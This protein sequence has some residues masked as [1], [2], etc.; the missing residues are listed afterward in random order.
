MA[1]Y[2][3]F[4]AYPDDAPIDLRF[5]FKD[6]RPAGKHGFLRANGD[7]FEFEDGTV[8]RF[9]GTNLNGGANFPD[10]DYAEKSARRLA[11]FGI[12][13]VRFH[14]IDAEWD[15]P[16]IYSFTKGPRIDTTRVL[17]PVSL[18]RLDYYIYC[19]KQE[20]IYCYMDSFTY[21]K[22]KNSDGIEN[23]IGLK[24][25]AKPYCMYNRRMI[26]LQKEMF[27]MLW[28]H[29]NP[30]TGLAY[31]DDPVFVMAELVNECDLF[32]WYPIET[33]PYA[34]E[35][36]KNF[37]AWLDSKGIEYDA[38]GCD[39]NE[40]ITGPLL[41]YK[42]EVQNSYF[43]EM[44]GYIRELGIK[45]PVTGTNWQL[46]GACTLTSKETDY[47]DNHHY[48]YDWHWG[49]FDKACM[50][51]GI[52]QLYDNGS[53]IFPKSHVDDMP[54]FIS[55]WD[56]PWPNSFRAEAPIFFASVGA[57][58]GYSGFAIH[59]YAYGTR[60][61]NMKMLGKEGSSQTIGGVSYREG[62]FS[63]WNDPA[64]FGLFYHAAL[65]T[66]RGDVAPASKKI[67]VKIND[68]ISS[69]GPAFTASSELSRI[70][71]D[72][73][74]GSAISDTDRTVSE[75]EI[76]VPEEA[77]EVRSDNGQLYR[78]WKKNL[79]TVDTELT[80]CVYGFLAKNGETELND[81]SVKC[82]NDFAV[83]AM[84]SLD[85]EKISSS[86]N[87]LLTT[88]GRAFN[89]DAR[90]LDEKMIDYG[91]PPIMIEVINADIKI[92]TECP[93]LRVWA[94]NSEGFYVGAI[95]S[96]YKDGVLS[97]TVGTNFRSMYYLIQSE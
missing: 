29:V 7:H 13:L 49:E 35:F 34:T 33:E 8:A 88:V 44:I 28:S 58:Q 46:F 47:I 17:D 85:G 10:R 4:P 62:I 37:R 66:R 55:E 15:T 64:K 72:L 18:D 51:K 70:V 24:D 27:S 75:N 54:M 9:W 38:E 76:L 22:F 3:P 6:E 21:R 11:K 57:L 91:H 26:E 36:R 97:F 40:K 80:K 92:R 83:V 86:K 78:S 71:V 95:P 94:V 43:N 45:I 87:I 93:D 74:D 68:L 19:L 42:I 25:A 2:I 65:I 32:S 89:Q 60:L 67:A 14:Q 30:Y 63:T 53:G 1:D 81:V 59:T 50:N 16:N 61:E 52:T 39:L 31:K 56:M 23:A 5:V 84:S 79:G 48:V 20:G 12:N 41:D 69:P 96:E 73:G 90:F 82:S 77:G